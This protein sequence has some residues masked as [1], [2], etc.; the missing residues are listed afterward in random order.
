MQVLHEG[1]SAD[2]IMKSYLTYLNYDTHNDWSNK[3]N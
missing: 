2:D 3:Q 1:G